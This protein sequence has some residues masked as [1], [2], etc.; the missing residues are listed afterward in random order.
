MESGSFRAI[1]IKPNEITFV[2]YEKRGTIDM[3]GRVR[4][5]QNEKSTSD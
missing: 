1:D 5:E 2:R 4:W 3:W